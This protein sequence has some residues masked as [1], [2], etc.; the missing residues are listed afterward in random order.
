MA[1]ALGRKPDWIATEAATCPEEDIEVGVE[2]IT[3]KS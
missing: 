1:E 2:R 3:V